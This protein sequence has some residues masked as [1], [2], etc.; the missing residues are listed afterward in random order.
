[1]VRNNTGVYLFLYVVGLN[2]LIFFEGFIAM[3]MRVCFVVLFS[4]KVF[5]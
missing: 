3:L 2:L 5:I 4:Y 1:M